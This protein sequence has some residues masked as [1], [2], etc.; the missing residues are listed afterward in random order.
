MIRGG[1]AFIYR[2]D[3][4]WLPH[5]SGGPFE[6][7]PGGHT[8]DAAGTAIRPNPL[9]TTTYRSGLVTLCVKAR[10]GHSYRI[11]SSTR[12]GGLDLYFIDEATGEPPKTPCGPDEDDD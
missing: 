2:F 11:K 12:P 10:G 5:A 7:R 9:W 3:R 6:V 4:V 8:V 1:D